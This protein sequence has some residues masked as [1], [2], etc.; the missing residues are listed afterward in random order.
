[1]PRL[2]GIWS[3]R[4][5]LADQV[6]V[7]F[8]GI[9]EHHRPDFA[10]SSPEVVFGV[11]AGCTKR[12]RLGSATTVLSADDPVRVFQRFSTLNA[13][14]GGRAEVI[15]GRGWFTEPFSLFGYELSDYDSLFEE[16]L[17]LFAA[18]SPVV[19]FAPTANGL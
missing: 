15:L 10:V 1:M 9:G 14:S 3:K 7:D 11:V 13:A 18:F 12:I 8:F 4:Q 2:F 19:T 5:C 6:G 16:K 17:T